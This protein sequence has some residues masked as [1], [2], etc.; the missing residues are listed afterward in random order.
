MYNKGGETGIRAEQETNEDVT[1][2]D[3]TDFSSNNE[4]N[5]VSESDNPE[6]PASGG[7]EDRNITNVVKTDGCES[8]HT[9]P[10]RI[11]KDTSEP[12]N[13]GQLTELLSNAQF[14]SE[15]PFQHEC[16]SG[17]CFDESSGVVQDDPR[18]AGKVFS[19]LETE[20]ASVD[21]EI[22]YS[23][24]FLGGTDEF[25][26]ELLTTENVS[27]DQATQVQQSLIRTE[28]DSNAG[29]GDMVAQGT[30]AYESENFQESTPQDEWKRDLHKMAD[31]V[32]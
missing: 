15:Y 27:D 21:N 19:Y 29:A 23:H 18:H 14:Y 7:T 12:A 30:N 25:L 5:I 10:E 17:N 31:R 3:K 20:S 8:D 24:D 32:R 4:N 13:S 2:S 22:F 28:D 11:V 6:Q 26:G 9:I 16:D 1:P